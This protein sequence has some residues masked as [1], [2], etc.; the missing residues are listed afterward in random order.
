MHFAEVYFSVFTALR[1]PSSQGSVIVTKRAQACHPE[2][3]ERARVKALPTMLRQA[4]HDTRFSYVM[5]ESR[6]TKF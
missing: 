4:Q 2:L 6:L 1:I 3:I 5:G